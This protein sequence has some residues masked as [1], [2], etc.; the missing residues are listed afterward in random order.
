[1]LTTKPKS[2]RP[3]Q[4]PAEAVAKLK[5]ELEQGEGFSSYKQVQAW[6]AEQLGIEA[7]YRT[8]HQLT[9]YRLKA[10]LKVA[11]PKAR[12]QPTERLEAFKKT[13]D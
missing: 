8:V 5:A 7:R 2:G 11:R 9:R 6:L 10:K 12:R 13:W 3:R 1:M 4:I